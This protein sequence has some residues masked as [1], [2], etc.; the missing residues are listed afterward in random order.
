MDSADKKEHKLEVDLNMKRIK[1]LVMYSGG[2]ERSNRYLHQALSDLVGPK[3]RKSFT[4]IPFCIDNHQTY[5][6]R[7]IRRYRYFGFTDFHCLPIDHYIHDYDLEVALRSDVIYL[8]GGNTFYFLKHLRK[9]GMLPLLKAFVES[10]GVLAGLSAGGLIMTPHIEL[11]GYPNFECDE[12]DVNLKNLRALNLLKLEFFPHYRDSKRMRES[13][14][15]Y[16]KNSKYPIY[17]CKDG[18]GLVINGVNKSFF[19]DFVIFNNGKLI[20]I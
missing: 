3:R 5:F 10:G 13:L 15:Q 9:S 19:G 11:A 14:I 7:A 2:Q 12:N 18:G 16:S 4:Y 17:A 1:K 20:R 8:A 6:K